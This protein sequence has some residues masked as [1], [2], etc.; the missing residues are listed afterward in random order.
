M[1]KQLF[2][3]NPPYTPH[4]PAQMA[5]LLN[6]FKTTFALNPLIYY[7]VHQID[8]ERFLFIDF[9][10]QS[11]LRYRGLEVLLIE[12]ATFSYYRLP[13]ARVGGTGEV[14]PGEYKVSIHSPS[15]AG[16][17]L[18][19]KKNPLGRFEL[20]GVAAGSIHQ[21]VTDHTELP[22]HVLE[23]SKFADELRAAV[24]AGVEWAY[25]HYRA[26]DASVQAR[27]QPTLQPTARALAGVSA[28]SDWLLWLLGLSF[29]Q[30]TP[31]P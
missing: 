1:L 25:Q 30:G 5:A 18:K 10:D 13:G 19:I 20:N 26:A 16:Y 7:W 6:A 12:G 31:K 24:T 22:I 28:E 9:F 4:T 17:L 14:A 15:G 8:A 27:L 3:R 29:S 11:M 2:N 21:L 23:P